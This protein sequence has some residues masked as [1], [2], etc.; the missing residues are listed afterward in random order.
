MTE[1]TL[2]QQ[3]IILAGAIRNH[4]VSPGSV[5]TP[6][7]GV[8]LVY[9][10]GMLCKMTRLKHDEKQFTPIKSMLELHDMSDEKIWKV[11]MR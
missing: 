3:K 11:V 1:P 5:F 10:D 9:R 2:E 8:S 4:M 7:A 6:L